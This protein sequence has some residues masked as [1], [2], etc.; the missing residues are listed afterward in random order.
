MAERATLL[1]TMHTLFD[2]HQID[3]ALTL[4]AMRAILTFQYYVSGGGGKG[5][6]LSTMH[7]LFDDHQSDSALT[8]A[9]MRAILMFQY[10][11]SGKVTRQCP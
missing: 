1:S 9:A 6:I 11:V 10:Y 2:D 5:T 3:S 4:V 7:P 8:L